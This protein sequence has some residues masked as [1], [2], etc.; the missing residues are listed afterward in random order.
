[1]T[2][3]INNDYFRRRLCELL[4]LN[5]DFRVELARQL[6]VP[7]QTVCAWESGED[8]PNV[9]QFRE[10]A[11][12][13]DL[14]YGWFLD[15]TDAAPD[16]GELAELLGLSESTV[17]ALSDMEKT[18]PPELLDAMDDTIFAFVSALKEVFGGGKWTA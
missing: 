10:I 11:A 6:R 14:P 4:T 3:S 17:E 16:T 5:E 1:M 15:G 12:F 18:A 9:Y 7:V 13:F 2:M 8:I